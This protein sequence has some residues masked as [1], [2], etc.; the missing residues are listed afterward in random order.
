MKTAPIP[1]HPAARRP[2]AAVSRIGRGAIP[3]LA[4]TLL[5]GCN[6]SGLGAVEDVAGPTGQPRLENGAPERRGPV[7][8]VRA[9]NA[10]GVARTAQPFTGY[11][12]PQRVEYAPNTVQLTQDL[13]ELKTSNTTGFDP[14][15]RI[16]VDFQNASV[17]FVLQQLL[18]GALG[19]NYVAP[20]NLPGTITFRTETPIPKSRVIDVVRD[21]LARND[22]VIRNING[23]YH[24]GSAAVI[25]GLVANAAIG[26][27]G[28]E[29][30]RIV[31]L[32][33]GNAAQVVQL[34]NAL[35]PGGVVLQTSSSPNTVVLRAS[36]DEADGVE[37]L[38]RTISQSAVGDGTVAI[39]PLSQSEPT[40][41]AERVT[42]FYA[43]TIRGDE[44]PVTVLPLEAQ[45]ALLVGTPDAQQMN[46]VRLLVQ[47]LD[48]STTD[49]SSLRVIP[50][51]HLRAEEI[52]PQ[53]SRVFGSGVETP[54][55]NTR[56]EQRAALT[57]VKR[58]SPNS[59]LFPRARLPGA[60][61]GPL[62]DG[63]L[64]T[65]TG[66]TL[67]PP[68]ALGVSPDPSGQVQGG[69]LQGGTA[70]G[71]RLA[72]GQDAAAGDEAAAIQGAGVSQRTT[73]QVAQPTSG[74]IRIVPDTR[75][76]TLLVYSSYR[77]YNQIREI[78]Q[79]LD[80]PEAQVVIEATVIEVTLNDRLERGVQFFLESNGI[81]AGSGIPSAVSPTSG[82]IVGFS[83]TLGNISVNAVLTAL[84]EV[85]NVKV[86]SSP[87][88]TVLNKR[89]ARLVIGDQIPFA[90]ATQSSNNLGNVTVTR[91]IQV[92][93][94]G[95]VMEITPQIHANNS[96]DLQISQSVSTPVASSQSQDLTPTIAT[97]DLQSQILVQSGRTVLLGGL[98]QDRVENSRTD[99]PVAADLPVIGNLFRQ[100]TKEA[101][102]NELLVLITPRVTRTSNELESITRLLRSAQVDGGGI[103][104]EPAVVKP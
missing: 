48:R 56:A 50:L 45:R 84:R 76:N 66:T 101:R 31:K 38:L 44:P 99:V 68:P 72:A 23:V 1:P 27:A 9:I 24:V 20:D 13:N 32:G 83:G 46:G 49:V 16:T 6:G 100:K 42:A 33:K 10:A 79:A 98:I 3:L 11:V 28:E 17:N 90:T 97:R 80:V 54:A 85:T 60:G 87:Y 21:L 18:G 30:T 78:V 104:R 96:V 5:A 82:G 81:G 43:S 67:A 75:T 93:D 65:G 26:S 12:G 36:P 94:T 53:V 15:E 61:E 22:L 39:L 86:V 7:V 55:S 14:N 4:L 88:L 69:Q 41:I 57:D 19:L 34:G 40:A 25:Q 51:T 37:R 73:P 92:V 29:V 70:T 2:Y 63:E 77:I 95:V 102:R 8:D 64:D 52:A 91:E 58:S 74:E 103:P 59:R 71:S 89:T 47:Q 62:S 35:V